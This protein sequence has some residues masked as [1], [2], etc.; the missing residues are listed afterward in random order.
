MFPALGMASSSVCPHARTY[1]K[2]HGAIR[3][4]PA[5]YLCG[6][7]CKVQFLRHG[8]G[9][10]AN[11]SSSAQIQRKFI[12]QSKP[13]HCGA[14]QWLL[15]RCEMCRVP[16]QEKM[17]LR[18]IRGKHCRNKKS[19]MPQKMGQQRGIFCLREC[20]HATNRRAQQE[21]PRSL[22]KPSQEHAH[23]HR[24]A[25]LGWHA[26]HRRGHVAKANSPIRFAKNL[27]SMHTMRFHA[28][29]AARTH[30]GCNHASH[31]QDPGHMPR[32]MVV[33]MSFRASA[34]VCEGRWAAARFLQW[35]MGKGKQ[36]AFHEPGPRPR[37]WIPMHA[38]DP[39]NAEFAGK[40]T[41]AG[42]FGS[43][44]SAPEVCL[45]L[46]SAKQ[47]RRPTRKPPAPA[48]ASMP[49]VWA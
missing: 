4:R 24:V 28:F 44:S 33:S 10:S 36:G 39:W 49:S 23:V 7:Q 6:T 32:L 19:W 17:L 1:T 3:G 45:H 18:K 9:K 22:R 38:R 46:Y 30:A 16:I 40:S 29:E 43:T 20:L 27:G 2:L 34:Q 26:P 21:K 31:A 13:T 25:C 41:C 15:F 35:I 5:E 42:V 14:R 8:T 12:L 47:R 11:R 37:A 48:F